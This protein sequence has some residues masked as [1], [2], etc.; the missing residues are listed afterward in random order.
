MSTTLSVA[1]HLFGP[2][3]LWYKVMVA[4]SFRETKVARKA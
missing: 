2:S 1:A 3:G 4:K